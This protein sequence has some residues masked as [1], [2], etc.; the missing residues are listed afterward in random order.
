MLG[1][2][3]VR[4]AVT[5]ALIARRALRTSGNGHLPEDDGCRMVGPRARP[6]EQ[7]PP[8]YSKYPSAFSASSTSLL[9]ASSA[10]PS[11]GGSAAIP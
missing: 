7:A 3:R 10:S 4:S 2:H 9:Y 11:G 6:G 8:A 1:R 5:C